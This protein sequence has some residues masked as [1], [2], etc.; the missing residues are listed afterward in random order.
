[1]LFRDSSSSPDEG[2]KLCINNDILPS[3]CVVN[4]VL[5]GQK[6]ARIRGCLCFQTVTR[7]EQTGPGLGHLYGPRWCSQREGGK[8]GGQWEEE[9]GQ[10][11]SLDINEDTDISIRSDLSLILISVIRLQLL[12]LFLFIINLI[13][14][15]IISEIS[16]MFVIYPVIH[17]SRKMIWC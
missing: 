4:P 13:L 2:S 1:M 16:E 5:F 6:P 14:S 8:V 15:F 9:D 17:N 10:S 7:E 11:D 3:I 12:Q